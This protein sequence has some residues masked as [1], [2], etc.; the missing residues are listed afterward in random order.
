MKNRIED[1]M[2]GAIILMILVIIFAIGVMVYHGAIQDVAFIGMM[3][4]VLV[5]GCIVSLY[6]LSSCTKNVWIDATVILTIL[7]VIGVVESSQYWL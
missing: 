1:M 3:I 5:F 2:L 4:L 7:I 6:I